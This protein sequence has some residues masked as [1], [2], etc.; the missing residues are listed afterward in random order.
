MQLIEF[1]ADNLPRCVDPALVAHDIASLARH[2]SS[3]A[4]PR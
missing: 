1:M 3:V 4:S 2:F